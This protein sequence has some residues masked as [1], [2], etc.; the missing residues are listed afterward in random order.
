MPAK[1]AR[2]T[3]T[4]APASLPR[5][6]VA[7]RQRPANP[8]FQPATTHFGLRERSYR[9]ATNVPTPRSRLAHLRIARRA[10]LRVPHP[11]PQKGPRHDHAQP[12]TSRQPTVPTRHHSFWT[13]G[14]QLPLCHPTRTAPAK[15]SLISASPIERPSGCRLLCQQRVRGT[16]PTTTKRRGVIIRAFAYPFQWSST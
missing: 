4:P 1:S 10:P 6:T 9:F 8:Q 5:P 14:A 12:P 15:A 11:L 3:I 2:G 13:A 7:S 16:I